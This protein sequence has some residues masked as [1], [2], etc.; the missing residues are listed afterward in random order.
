MRLLRQASAGGRILRSGETLP[1]IVFQVDLS[2]SSV[3]GVT[4]C[5]CKYCGV[6][7]SQ[8]FFVRDSKPCCSKCHKEAVEECW[9]CK[10]KISEDHIYCNKKYYHPKCMKV[11][12]WI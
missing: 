6:K 12:Y 11:G 2:L 7:L 9:V 3:T 4:L 10:K 1:Q 5:R 8:I